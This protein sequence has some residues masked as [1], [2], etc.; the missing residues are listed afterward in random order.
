MVLDCA[1][2]RFNVSVILSMVMLITSLDPPAAVGQRRVD[3]TTITSTTMPAA[4]IEIDTAFAYVGT[5]TITLS[6]GTK[7][8]QHF[9]V[10][11]E[12]RRVR[13]LFWLQFEGKA[14]GGRPYDYS[15][16]AT[17]EIWGHLFHTDARFYPTSGF[18]GRPG[19]DGDRAAQLLARE[20]YV[21]GADLMRIRLVWLLDDPPLNELM[22]IYLEDLAD[23]GLT[24]GD[25]R[26][27]HARWEGLSAA[28]QR[29]AVAGMRL[30][31]PP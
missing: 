21:L 29:R 14:E 30:V 13:R 28:L 5:Q 6:S 15:R 26:E 22:V 9:F 23:H 31:S 2:D 27:D 3:G 7:A 11:A 24:V 12:G 8:E 18:A 16:D 17:T 4:R 10:D 19:S 1:H 25:L 20:G